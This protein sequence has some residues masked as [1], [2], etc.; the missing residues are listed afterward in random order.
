MNIHVIDF[1]SPGGVGVRS[2]YAVH[3]ALDCLVLAC[4]FC[5]AARSV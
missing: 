3:P 2:S 4:I 1:I 5:F